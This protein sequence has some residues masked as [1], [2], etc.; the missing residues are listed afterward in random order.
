MQLELNAKLLRAA[1]E[2]SARRVRRYLRRGADVG[3]RDALGY[4]ALLLSASHGHPD[5]VECLCHATLL[6][7][8]LRGMTLRRASQ[9]R[10][11]HVPC[12]RCFC[13]CHAL[14]ERVGHHC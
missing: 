10:G 8:Y 3:S 1:R 12:L 11:E 5:C 4:C 9:T 13:S 7:R 6:G 2:G 14:A